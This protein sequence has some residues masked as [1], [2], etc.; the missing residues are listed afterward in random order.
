MDSCRD[1]SLGTLLTK[2]IPSLFGAYLSTGTP[3]K[4]NLGYLEP[5]FCRASTTEKSKKQREGITIAVWLTPCFKYQHHRHFSLDAV[6][7]WIL[8]PTSDNGISGIES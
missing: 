2:E 8:T 5:F 1:G 6:F 4:H 3:V 7:Q